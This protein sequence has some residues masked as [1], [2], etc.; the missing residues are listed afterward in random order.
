MPRS[1]TPNFS[2]NNFSYIGLDASV[3][4]REVSTSVTRPAIST[5]SL[6][7]SSAAKYASTVAPISSTPW[8]IRRSTSGPLSPISLKPLTSAVIAPLDFSDRVL[9]QNGS[10]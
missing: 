2:R 5:A 8:L 4:L 7:G 10:S 3:I 9:V 1:F 6:V